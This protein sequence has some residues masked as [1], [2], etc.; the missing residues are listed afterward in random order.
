MLLG[1][2]AHGLHRGLGFATSA[3]MLTDPKA[4]KKSAARETIL[5][6]AANSFNNTE[7]EN[8]EA[9]ACQA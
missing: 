5:N 2:E 3:R 4:T 6:Y 9:V 8:L 7:T 1:L